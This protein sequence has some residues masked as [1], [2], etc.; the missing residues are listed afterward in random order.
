MNDAISLDFPAQKF[1]LIFLYSNTFLNSM[2]LY[3]A[4]YT[5]ENN[6]NK[7]SIK[8][9]GQMLNFCDFIQ[10]YVFSTNHH[11][12]DKVYCILAHQSVSI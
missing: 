6:K 2:S 4:L 12:K 8:F 11:L 7:K 9:Q 5:V 3:L 1:P 10:V